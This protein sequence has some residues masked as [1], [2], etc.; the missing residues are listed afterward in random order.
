[1]DLYGHLGSQE[2]T[3]S[4]NQLLDLGGGLCKT[5]IKNG[6][7]TQFTRAKDIDKGYTWPPNDWQHFPA[8]MQSRMC[9]QAR[10]VSRSSPHLLR[11]FA[12]PSISLYLVRHVHPGVLPQGGGQSLAAGERRRVLKARPEQEADRQSMPTHGRRPGKGR[13]RFQCE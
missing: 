8:D 3:L 7:V 11:L 2:P 13:I 4:S 5:D 10:A 1:M 6:L 12:P 9:F